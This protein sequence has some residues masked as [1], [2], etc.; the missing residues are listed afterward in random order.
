MSK[1]QWDS[2]ALQPYCAYVSDVRVSTHQCMTMLLSFYARCA[3]NCMQDYRQL[4]GRIHRL[5][6]SA[7]MYHH[8][9]YTHHRVSYSVVLFL[10]HAVL[11][12][13]GIDH[14]SILGQLPCHQSNMLWHHALHQQV[15]L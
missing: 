7:S 4:D 15:G 5:K 6:S 12:E 14:Q 2:L 3:G 1:H 9:A 11:H 8:D 10:Q 13:S